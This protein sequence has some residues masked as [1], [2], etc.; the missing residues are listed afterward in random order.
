ME[1][2]GPFEDLRSGVALFHEADGVFGKLMSLVAFLFEDEGREAVP[3][4]SLHGT[5]LVD[6]YYTTIP[7]K[8][9]S[10]NQLSSTPFSYHPPSKDATY[11]SSRSLTTL[12]TLLGSQSSFGSSHYKL[13]SLPAIRILNRCLGLSSLKSRI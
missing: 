1:H 2:L 4:G 7:S 11:L 9:T 12:L 6:K 10:T 5:Y 8:T 3:D 13:D